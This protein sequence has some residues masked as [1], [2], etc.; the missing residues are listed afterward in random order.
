MGLRSHGFKVEDYVS[1]EL[2]DSRGVQ[3]DIVH[4]VKETNIIIGNNTPT[5][6][7]CSAAKGLVSDPDIRVQDGLTRLT[8]GRDDDRTATEGGFHLGG[9]GLAR[10]SKGRGE[11]R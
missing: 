11:V 7:R 3:V 1:M 9:K 4:Q 2:G 5:L 6:R 8:D 10:T